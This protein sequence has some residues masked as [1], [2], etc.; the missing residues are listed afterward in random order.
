VWSTEVGGVD[1]REV[2]TVSFLIRGA[3]GG[4]KPNV[5]LDDGN[6]RWGVP[7]DKYT[8]L[9]KDWT[10]VTIPLHDFADFGIDLSHIDEFQL[11]F[12]WEKMS[13]TVYIADITFGRSNPSEP[14][15]ST[16]VT[17]N[18]WPDSTGGGRRDLR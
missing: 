13:G 1:C 14:G 5:Y 7:I 12:E 6:H 2:R 17:Q 8:R 9:T 4:E 16:Q 11:A 3:A 15:L 18:A 10:R